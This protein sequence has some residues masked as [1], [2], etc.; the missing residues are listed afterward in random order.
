VTGAN[1]RMENDD[2]LLCI[3]CGGH[4]DYDED[5]DNGT[6]YHVTTGYYSCDELDPRSP[7][8]APRCMWSPDPGQ[9]GCD[10]PGPHPLK[11]K[12]LDRA[13]EEVIRE[14]YLAFLCQRHLKVIALM[15]ADQPVPHKLL[16][17]YTIEEMP[18]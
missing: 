15:A 14:D 4:V 8:A 11:E 16:D 10:Q 2:P 13:T 18:G 3:H 7:Q 12:I 5:E 1:L 6:F 9:P 17:P